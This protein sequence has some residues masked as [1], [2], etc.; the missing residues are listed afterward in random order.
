MK[1]TSSQPLITAIIP[2]YLRPEKLRRAIESLLAQTYPHLQVLV[3]D[4]ASDDSTPEVVERIRARDSRVIYHRHPENIGMFANFDYG[5]RRVETPFFCFL[6]N[7]DVV[8]PHFFETAM[9]GFRTHPEASLSFG[10]TVIVREPNHIVK[11]QLAGM[12]PGRYDPPRGAFEMLKDGFTTWSSL[13]MRREVVDE[14]GY[15]EPKAGPYSDFLFIMKAALRLPIVISSRPCALFT[16]HASSFTASPRLDRVWP[17]WD[18][19]IRSA[20]QETSLQERE[21]EAL[22]RMLVDRAVKQLRYISHASARGGRYADAVEVAKILAERFDRKGS[23]FL[24]EL[25]AWSLRIVPGVAWV[26]RLVGRACSRMYLRSA[27]RAVERSGWPGL[28]EAR[29]YLCLLGDE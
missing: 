6:S 12:R 7:D 24:L 29:R 21:R 2:T 25:F 20:G 11:A 14:V 3:L 18:V 28:G 10:V 8:L 26:A 13:L 15:F 1:V 23:G 5:L 4:D 9:E 16:R 27:R 17:Y 19:L 22:V